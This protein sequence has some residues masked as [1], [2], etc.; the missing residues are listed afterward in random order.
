[1]VKVTNKIKHFI[2]LQFANPSKL[3]GGS[4]ELEQQDN[5]QANQSGWAPGQVVE[6]PSISLVSES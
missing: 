1:M 5:F 3:W 2:D 4:Q 6:S